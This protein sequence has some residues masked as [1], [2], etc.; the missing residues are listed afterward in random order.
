MITGIAASNGSFLADLNQL[1]NR[2]SQTSQQV[3]SGIRVNQASD[4]PSA[5]A[6]ILDYQNQ[7]DQITQ[8]QTNLDYANT[9]VKTAD[10][11]LQ[12]ASSLMNQL[13]SI[14]AQGATSTATPSSRTELGQQVQQ[15]EQQL[16]LIANT[17]VQGR[18]I[19]GGDQPTIQPYTF[20]W[21]S[22]D[23]VVANSTPTNTAVIADASGS[24]IV[25]GL[26]A[27]Q[28]FDAQNAGGGA[29]PNNVFAAAYS[30]GQALLS[31]DQPGIQNA[32]TAISA[33]ATQV[34]QSN[35]YYGNTETW[36][37]QATTDAASRLTNLRTAL[38]G[39]RDTDVAQAATE[40]QTDQ[41]ALEAALAAHASLDN[42]T[43]FSFLG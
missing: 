20:D 18:Y 27:Q 28:I 10:G 15:I 13:V 7:I 32:T 16:V 22:P 29:A 24:T 40:L 3:S 41:T 21:S 31:N 4:D 14:A 25:P 12:S 43:L 26:T 1:E 37:G 17:T 19:F 36:I 33:A 34:A 11:A 38:S 9:D 30:L 2:I 35:E 39:L 6:S 8:T 42:R 5:I 23:G